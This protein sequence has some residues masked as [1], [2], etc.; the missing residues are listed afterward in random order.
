M[1]N[2]TPG[3]IDTLTR[4][5][6]GEAEPGNVLDAEAIAWVVVNRASLPPWPSTILEVCLQP[7]QFICWNRNDPNRKRIEGGHGEWFDKCQ[8]VAKAVVLRCIA[9]PTHRSTHYYATWVKEPKWAHG[10][11]PVYA[12]KHKAG[13]EHRFFND[14]DT[15]APVAKGS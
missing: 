1:R 2:P 6:Y 4:T 3:D 14:I 8:L 15:K 5:L 11:T 12:V 9:D 7:L 10:H 13:D